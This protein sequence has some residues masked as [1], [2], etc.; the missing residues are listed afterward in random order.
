MVSSLLIV[1]SLLTRQFAAN[2]HG[3]KTSPLVAWRRTLAPPRLVAPPPP[4]SRG[5]GGSRA[6]IQQ[7]RRSST[8]PPAHP[9]SPLPPPPRLP[10]SRG[11]W[12]YTRGTAGALQPPTRLP[13]HRG[14]RQGC[15][16][17]GASPSTWQPAHPHSCTLLGQHSERWR[18]RQL[19]SRFEARLPHSVRAMY[20][21]WSSNA[22]NTSPPGW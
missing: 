16:A 1:S 22:P 19:H 12:R 5:G 4:P 10:L 9:S 8:P 2:H 21:F 18:A 17:G 6:E 15:Q 14:R 7:P 11:R 3:V 20:R 13:R